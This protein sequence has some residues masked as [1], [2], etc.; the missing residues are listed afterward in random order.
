MKNN[1]IIEPG[2]YKDQIILTGSWTKDVE[3][4]IRQHGITE[5]CLNHAKGWTGDSIDFLETIADQIEVFTL[6]DFHIKDITP[7]HLLRNLKSIDIQTYCNTK[8]DFSNFP[9]LKKCGFYWRKNVVLGVL[10]SIEDLFIYKY[11]HEDLSLLYGLKNLRRLRIKFSSQLDSLK[12]INSLAHL[13]VLELALCSK[14]ESLDEV[15]KLGSLKELALDTCKK[16]SNIKG[17]ESLHQLRKLALNNCGKIDSL[18]P[19][20]TLRNLEEVYFYEST[21]VEDGDINF[22]LDLPLLKKIAYQ[23]RK[24][25]SLKRDVFEKKL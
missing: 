23:D 6:L 19:I 25:Y 3:A 17:I 18:K 5:L 14:L 11:K 7:I 13:E 2:L 8:L 24:H 9:K 20:A 16:V 21:N 22:L 12:G 15:W 4:Y 1:F 10:P